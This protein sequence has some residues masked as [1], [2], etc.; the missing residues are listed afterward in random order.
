MNI[1][2]LLL[3]LSLGLSLMT[4]NSLADDAQARAIMVKVDARD[5]GQ[6]IKQ[7]MM[8]ILIDKN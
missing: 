8:M 3:G 7:D 1:K 6:T 4:T 2:K 5:D